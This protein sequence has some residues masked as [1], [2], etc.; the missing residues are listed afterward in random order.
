[1]LDEYRVGKSDKGGVPDK[2][3]AGE[4]LYPNRNW[5]HE[6]QRNYTCD[7]HEFLTGHAAGSDRPSML[8]YSWFA[9]IGHC[10]KYW[11]C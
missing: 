6:R 5:R 11:L 3:R 8:G 4:R 1:M 7:A 9:C 10:A 2:S